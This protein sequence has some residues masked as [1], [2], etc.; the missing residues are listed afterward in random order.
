[1]IQDSTSLQTQS[2]SLQPAAR[3][4]RERP[5]TDVQAKRQK[6][7]PMEIEALHFD[8]S[9]VSDYDCHTIPV[10][11]TNTSNNSRQGDLEG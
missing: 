4:K 10:S 6:L 9:D 2:N 11:G 8:G 1:M 5:R 3:W 7:E